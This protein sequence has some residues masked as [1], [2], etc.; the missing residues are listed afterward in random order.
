MNDIHLLTELLTSFDRNI[1]LSAT[2]YHGLDPL[3]V[4]V[5]CGLLTVV[6][7]L[8]EFGFSAS[9]ICE[10]KPR[11]IPLD[12]PGL[13]VLHIACHQGFSDI[14]KALLDRG[15][16]PNYA[17]GDGNT[18][19]HI[20]AKRNAFPCIPPLIEGGAAISVFNN[21]G[22]TP[23]HCASLEDNHYALAKVRNTH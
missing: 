10:I 2:N 3:T 13:S 20:A 23:F 22:F 1:V 9:T 15:A 16:D 21:E 17:S 6:E 5:V 4:A 8:L 18:P 12:G 19:L 14:V 11:T 7:I